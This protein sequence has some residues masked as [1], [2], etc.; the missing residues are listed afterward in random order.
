MRGVEGHGADSEQVIAE[1]GEQ[2][3]GREQPPVQEDVRL[4]A[5]RHARSG[6]RIG[7]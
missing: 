4:L 3:L 7:R 6:Y 1:S 2:S 5:L